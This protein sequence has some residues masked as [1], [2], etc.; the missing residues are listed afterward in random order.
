MKA[1]LIDLG[2]GKIN[3][4][5][6]VPDTKSLHKEIQKHLASKNWNMYES[7]SEPGIWLIDAGFRTVG[8]VKI[9]QE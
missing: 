8:K 5:V 3:K 1:Q 2:R 4:E 6:E 7:D 9:I